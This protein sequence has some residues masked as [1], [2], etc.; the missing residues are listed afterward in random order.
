M[1]SSDLTIVLAAASML[2]WAPF[3][4]AWRCARAEFWLML[5]VAALTLLASM[6]LALTVGVALSA[7]LLLQR[8][9]VPHVARIGRVPGTEHFRNVSRHQV[10]EMPG[11]VALRIDESLLFTNARALAGTVQAQLGDDTR[12]VV[13]LMSPV[14]T[15]DLSGL[16]ALL[17]LDEALHARGI[18]LDL[19]EVK[20]PVMDGLR[21]AG[22]D[23]Q[24]HGHQYLSLHQAMQAPSQGASPG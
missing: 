17:A 3:R 13:L 5:G 22:W 20:G 14:N 10:E 6:E 12:R 18:Q 9:A 21:A 2:Q 1:C 23:E 16:T 19:A 8:T 4:L 24:A 7:A 11:V 15:V